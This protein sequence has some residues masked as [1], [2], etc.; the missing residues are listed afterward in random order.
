MIYSNHKRREVELPLDRQ[1]YANLLE[2]LK[3]HR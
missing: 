2:D 1:A 3:A